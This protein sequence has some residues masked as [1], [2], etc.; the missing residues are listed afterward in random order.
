M[1]K[2]QCLTLVSLLIAGVLTLSSCSDSSEFAEVKNTS[3]NT[4]EEA[5]IKSTSANTDGIIKRKNKRKKKTFDINEFEALLAEQPLYVSETGLLIQDAELKSIYPD[6]LQ[7]IIVNNTNEDIKNAV[8]A[9]VA[10]D[11]NNLPIKIAGQFYTNPDPDSYITE[12]E[13]PDINLIGGSSYGENNGFPLAENSNI[14]KSKAI[15]VSYETFNGETWENPYYDNFNALYSGKKYSDDLTVE[16]KVVENTPYVR[17][18]SDEKQ[19]TEVTKTHMSA[20]ELENKLKSLP[21]T[22]IE[23]NYVIQD[24]QYKGIHPDF[25]EVIL[26]NNSSDDIKDAIIGFVAWD[27]NNLPVKIEPQFKSIHDD[28]SYVRLVDYSDINLAAGKTFGDNYG[29]MLAP[30]NDIKTFKAIVVSYQSFEDKIWKNP[31]F[32]D[33]CTL[34]EGVKLK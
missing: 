22:I 32:D 26:Q 25:L 21:I 29:F 8:I 10:W 16:V 6:L 1:S 33:F 2:K 11:R 31:Y 15:V 18:N 14:D 28:N 19:T 34:Y 27:S 9:F 12:V 17:A 23:T 24:E 30:T 13:Y 3:I 7:A 5:M 20:E 4:A